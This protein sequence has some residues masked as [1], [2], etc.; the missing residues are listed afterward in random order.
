MDVSNF[1]TSDW[2]KIGGGVVFFIA[3]FLTWWKVEVAGFSDGANAFEWFF[4]GTVPWLIF[5]AIA[6]LAL[7]AAAGKFKLP[8][9]LPAP[10]I[11]L[12]ASALGFLLVLVR[13]ISD[14]IDGD[15]AESL[16]VDISRG[17]GLYLAFLAAI[18]VV[19]GCVLAFKESGG[20]L[21]DLKDFNKLKSAFDTGGPGSAGSPPP[22]PP[23]GGTPPPPPPPVA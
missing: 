1:K 22:P 21:N 3:G 4:T 23:A 20:D 12:A 10:L 17:I 18:A 11:Y 5:T 16:G 6:V 13:F 15:E 19:V 7:L 8:G 14:G 9:N 2:L